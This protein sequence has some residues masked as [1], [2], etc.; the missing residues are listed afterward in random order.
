MHN[1]FP[2]DALTQF[3]TNFC[4]IEY[5]SLLKDLDAWM[6]VNTEGFF[7]DLVRE[8]NSQKC[9]IRSKVFDALKAKVAAEQQP[10]ITRGHWI[11]HGQARDRIIQ[12]VAREYDVVRLGQVIHHLI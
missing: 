11:P 8:L 9:G 10:V 1:I 7:S 4:G 12:A 6:I 2:H 5:G 3:L